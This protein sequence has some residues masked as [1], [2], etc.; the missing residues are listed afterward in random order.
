MNVLIYDSHCN[1][2]SRF[3]QFFVKFNKNDDIFIT[4]FDSEYYKKL[5]YNFPKDT[6][7]FIKGT[8]L[9]YFSDAIIEALVSANSAF[10]LLYILKV[11]PKCTRDKIYRF[12]AKNRGKILPSKNCKLPTDKYKAMYLS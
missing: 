3:I 7:V 9:Y 2:C 8:E 11:I 5:N 10:K 4:D 1:M 12:I 6:A